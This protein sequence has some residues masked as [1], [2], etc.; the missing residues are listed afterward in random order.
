M[1]IDDFFATIAG[2][3]EDLTIIEENFVIYKDIIYSRVNGRFFFSESLLMWW[4][5]ETRKFAAQE[6]VEAFEVNLIDYENI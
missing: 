6:E 3:P 1:N 4:D 5:S 2:E